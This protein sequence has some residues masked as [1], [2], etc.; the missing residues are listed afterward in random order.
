MK[1]KHINDS[2]APSYCN[3]PKKPLIKKRNPTTT[4][5][6]VPWSLLVFNFK[7]QKKACVQQ[8][9]AVLRTKVGPAR[10]WKTETWGLSCGRRN[11]G[12]WQVWGSNFRCYLWKNSV[13]IYLITHNSWR[14]TS[15]IFLWFGVRLEW[16][17]TETWG[18]VCLIGKDWNYRF[19]SYCS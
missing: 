16:R 2:N 3:I 8:A 1:V 7:P 12:G 6:F 18:S 10:E 4:H 17:R 14:I 5:L 13:K 9:G 15:Q 11:L 19:Y